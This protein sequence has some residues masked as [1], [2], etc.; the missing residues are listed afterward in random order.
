ANVGFC[1]PYN[2]FT[3]GCKI[4]NEV[5][6]ECFILSDSVEYQN[7]RSKIRTI[8]NTK[9]SGN[10]FEVANYIKQLCISRR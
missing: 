7:E 6:L 9:P 10:C 4:Y 3:P 5:D 8:T 1:Y 2:E